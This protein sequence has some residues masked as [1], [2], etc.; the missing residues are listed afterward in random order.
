VEEYNE[1]KPNWKNKSILVLLYMIGIIVKVDVINRIKNIGIVIFA[2]S[3]A[4]LQ[5]SPNTKANK[6]STMKNKKMNIGTEIKNSLLMVELNVFTIFPVL[7]FSF[8]A[9]WKKLV[10]LN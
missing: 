4:I 8:V 6:S 5:V 2:Y 9:C 7:C 10:Q 1:T 3:P